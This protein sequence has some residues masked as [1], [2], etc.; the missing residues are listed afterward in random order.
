MAVVAAVATVRRAD[1][2][3][4][5][6][7]NVSPLEQLTDL[8][9]RLRQFAELLEDIVSAAGLDRTSNGAASTS[10]SLFPPVRPSQPSGNGSVTPSIADRA[11]FL[12]HWEGKTCYL[13]NTI[14]FKLLER[15]AR[16]PNHLVSCEILLQDVWERRRS[17]EA[18]R[19]AVKV[20]RQKLT[21]AGM[22]D[23]AAAIDGSTAH[24]YRLSLNGHF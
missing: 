11:T 2:M 15:L 19:S 12:A 13:G 1:A 16:R 18:V 21:S 7:R 22:G 17:P 14:F 24:H 9:A 3:P 20:L 6:E 8:A 5:L 23:L 10:C 4:I